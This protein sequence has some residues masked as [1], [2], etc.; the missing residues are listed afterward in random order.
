MPKPSPD[1]DYITAEWYGTQLDGQPC[2]GSIDIE[3]DGAGPMLDPSTTRPLDVFPVVISQS[4]QTT[5]IQV[6]DKNGNPVT[7]NVGYAV[8]ELPASN[9]PDI[10]GGGATYTVTERLE[11]AVGRTYS[12]FVDKDA[13]GGVIRL[14]ELTPTAPTEQTVVSVVTVAGFNALE[15]RV[16]GLE[17]VFP[18]SVVA[19]DVE[20]TSASGIAATDVQA[21]LVELAGD[22]TGHL[23]DTTAAHAASAISFTPTGTI[24]ATDVQAAIAE[25]ASEA[26]SGGTAAGTSFTPNGSIAATNVQAA[27]QEVRDEAAGAGIFTS[28]RLSFVRVASSALPADVRSQCDYECD[29]VNDQVQINQALLL[30]SR[31]GDGFGGEGYGGVQL[32]GPS[33]SIADD[34]ATSITM[35]PSTLLQGAG[36]G[37]LLWPKWSSS[38]VDRACIELLNTNVHFVTVADLSIGRPT[39]VNANGHGIKF[40][41]SGTGD[42][43]EI[44]SSSDPFNMIRGV[45]I[46]F[47]S[48]KG[49]WL[50][51]TSGGS[52]ESQVF[53]VDVKSC[54]EQGILIDSS[55]DSQISNCRAH[56]CVGVNFELG[57][58][59][60]KIADCKAYYSDTVGFLISSS[61]C[62]ADGI[63][64]QDNGTHGIQVTGQDARVTGASC[65]SNSR[66][67][68]T[69]YGFL[70]SSTGDFEGIECFDRG[71]TPGSPQN[72]AI[73]ITGSPQ[74]YLSGRTRVPAG[75][76][77]L[78]GSPGA[79]SYVRVVRDGTTIY[80]S[81]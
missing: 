13:P 33:F 56:G 4:L 44:K 60:T 26:G 55:S 78:T 43:Y 9:D 27:I 81:G 72:R 54:G 2:R 59:N 77:H 48:R 50:T 32:V 69:A 80:S 73:G 23:A 6:N 22:I 45:R 1:F 68:T 74:I 66:L 67:S 65:D 25:V 52:R 64:A 12:L 62:E 63:A 21:A 34:N 46:G 79:N 51:G 61:R 3:Y 7:V 30:A 57:G 58:G 76:A 24:A 49:I 11:G 38:A 41:Q 36:R 53:E 75:G 8:F 39:A 28:R 70:I 47:M 71:Q 10:L 42:A 40:N 5:Q 29:G 37:T 14:N 31:P 35:Y 16:A 17:A 15:Q 19:A 18:S 20:F